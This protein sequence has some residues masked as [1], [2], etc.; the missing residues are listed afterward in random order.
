[1]IREEVGRGSAGSS[2]VARAGPRCHTSR[3]GEIIL[4]PGP[5]VGVE[6]EQLEGGVEQDG[7][8]VPCHRIVRAEVARIG[9]TSRRNAL[10][11][12]RLCPGLSPIAVHVR[13]DGVSC[14]SEMYP[15]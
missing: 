15:L 8:H 14:G 7:V 9:R 1:V 11:I 4:V 10:I 12:S 5:A 3:P 2:A 13:E 6:R